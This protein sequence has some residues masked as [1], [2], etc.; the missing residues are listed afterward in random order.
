MGRRRLVAKDTG[1][2]MVRNLAAAGDL[3]KHADELQVPGLNVSIAEVVNVSFKNDQIVRKQLI[4]E[5]AFNYIPHTDASDLLHPLTVTIPNVFDKTILNQQYVQAK[6]DNE[7]VVDTLKI[8][9]KTLGG[10]KYLKKLDSV[11]ILMHQVWK[12]EEH[13]ASL[14]VSLKLNPDYA[15]VLELSGVVVVATRTDA[16]RAVSAASKPPGTFSADHN[17]ITWR[18]ND[19]TLTSE[20]SQTLIARFQ[21]NGKGEENDAGIQLNF[22]VPQPPK[23]TEGFLDGSQAPCVRSLVSGNDSG[24]T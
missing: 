3:F 22:T 6:S 19:L 5:V 4:G 17:R 24:H 11:P 21:T 23:S 16:V 13:Q 10:V 14:L 15:S 7:Y 9:S 12:F 18:L 20:K 1:A 8:V 2:S